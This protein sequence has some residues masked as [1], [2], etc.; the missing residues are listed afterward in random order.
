MS[1]QEIVEGFMEKRKRIYARERLKFPQ[2]N[3]TF[4]ENN[5][6]PVLNQILVSASLGTEEMG[7][8]LD[9]AFE[10]ESLDSVVT[11]IKYYNTL[12]I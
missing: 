9:K 7:R 10:D 12:E 3:W 2:P 6:K 11:Y 4:D 8:Q 1:N 5:L